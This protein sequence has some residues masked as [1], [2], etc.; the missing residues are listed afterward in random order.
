[1]SNNDNLLLWPPGQPFP[2]FLGTVFD[3]IWLS[4]PFAGLDV[5]PLLDMGKIDVV[6]GELVGQLG[7]SRSSVAGEVGGFLQFRE[8]NDRE[9]LRLD[10]VVEAEQSGVQR[11]SYGR[12]NDEV[13]PLVMGEVFL[14]LSAL[15]LAQGSEIRVVDLGVGIAQVVQALCMADEVDLWC[16]CV[17]KM[18]K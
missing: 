4:A 14:E 18:L 12:G 15:L 11:P 5:P 7:G 2:C 17:G 13:D 16:H 6:F 1:M 10:I 3:G 8:G 9:V